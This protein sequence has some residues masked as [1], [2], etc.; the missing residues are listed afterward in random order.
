MNL[1]STVRPTGDTVAN[2]HE[3]CLHWSYGD[4]PLSDGVSQRRA[5]IAPTIAGPTT[6]CNGGSRWTAVKLRWSYGM[7]TEQASAHPIEIQKQYLTHVCLSFTFAFAFFLLYYVNW[8][9]YFAKDITVKS[10]TKNTLI[11]VC[12]HETPGLCRSTSVTRRS[13]TGALPQIPAAEP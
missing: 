13:D 6:V 12:Y 3:L 1:F 9:L 7:T 2:R 5:G 4:S 10:F 11:F 8:F